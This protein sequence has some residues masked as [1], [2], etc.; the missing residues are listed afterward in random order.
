[1]SHAGGEP[2]SKGVGIGVAGLERTAGPR[3]ARD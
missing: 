1:M 2:D 3:R